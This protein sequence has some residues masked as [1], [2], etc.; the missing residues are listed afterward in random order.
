[1]PKRSPRGRNAERVSVHLSMPAPVAARLRAYAAHER[2]DM[3]AVV[4][5][6]LKTHLR[7]FS[8]RFDAPAEAIAPAGIKLAQPERAAP[9]PAGQGG[10][11]S[12]GTE[13]G[14]VAA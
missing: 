2:V 14:P 5:D 8:V 9:R 4:A 13:G 10:S 11:G 3:S 6:A 12:E 7:G 1:M